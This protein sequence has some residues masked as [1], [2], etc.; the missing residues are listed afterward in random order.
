[1]RASITTALLLLAFGFQGQASDHD[2]FLYGTVHTSSGSSY[3]GFLRWGSQE[4]F[5]DD[6]F[7]SAKTELP[8]LEDAEDVIDGDDERH[9]Q[10]IRVFGY[11]IEWD[12]E[13]I[14][15]SRVFIARFGDIERIEVT[16][17][18]EA[19]LVMKSGERYDVRG[20]SDDVGGEIHVVDEERGEIDVR[21]RRIDSIE[22]SAAPSNAR[23][24]SYRLRGTVQ[25]AGG[26]FRG[27]VQWDGE[28]CRGS[29]LL[30]GESE[31]GDMSIE[32]ED[33]RSIE[34]RG[35][36]SSVVELRDGQTLRLRGSNDVN[37]DNRGIYVEDERYGRVKILWEDFDR[38]DFDG[39]GDSGRGYDDY[40]PL[41]ALK[42][43]LSDDDDEDH[44]GRIVYDLDE[45]EYWEI[46]NGHDRD[47]E[48]NIPFALIESIEPQGERDCLVTLRGGEE[49]MLEDSQ[50]VSAKN[51]GV[52]VYTGDRGK[53][54]HFGWNDIRRIRFER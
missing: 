30:D 53:P 29:D 8:F 38:V 7:H 33:I 9:R 23:P 47:I 2:G 11:R 5:W 34:R 35:R 45:S 24:D 14:S 6:L 50:D 3:T 54:R 32:F 41:G 44:Q 18:D 16:G 28:E 1:M 43:T 17:E 10:R 49:L 26:E 25:S 13:G 20:Y 36:R 4:S 37:Q 48:Y 42:G 15:S 51:D 21:W 19:R 22:F 27:Y 12:S 39:P 46:L 52:L 31:D 40:E